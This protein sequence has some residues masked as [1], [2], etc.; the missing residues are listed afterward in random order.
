MLSIGDVHVGSADKS[1]PQ[2]SPSRACVAPAG[3]F[4]ALRAQAPAP[5]ASS[6]P[7]APKQLPAVVQRALEALQ[8]AEQQA[9]CV[10]QG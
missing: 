7:K 8:Q 6:A 10:P 4:A 9:N 3:Q 1:E 2:P 5:V